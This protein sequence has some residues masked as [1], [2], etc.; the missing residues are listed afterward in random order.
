MNTPESSEASSLNTPN[1][2]NAPNADVSNN[3]TP[4][5]KRK[6]FYIG[7]FD[8]RG[9]KYYHHLYK[10]EST[11][12]A[13]TLDCEFD[14]SDLE[15]TQ[16]GG[17]WHICYNKSQQQE[18]TQ[19]N[20]AYEYLSYDDQVQEYFQPVN[21]L[22]FTRTMRFFFRFFSKWLLIPRKYLTISKGFLYTA[23]YPLIVFALALLLIAAASLITYKLT[24]SLTS[25][26][27]LSALGALGA[28][29]IVHWLIKRFTKQI[30][31]IWL[32]NDFCY[33][34]KVVRDDYSEL[35]LR[36]N[37]FAD[38]I[39]QYAET[40]DDDEIL[41]VF[42]SFGTLL[43]PVLL[44]KLHCKLETQESQSLSVLSLG[45]SLSMVPCWPNTEHYR[46][47]LRTI[48]NM[49]INWHDFTS[50]V[51]GPCCPLVNIYQHA[52]VQHDNDAPGLPKT[53]SARFH[54]MFS[55]ET[56]KAIK[57][58]RFRVHFQYLMATEK[59]TEYDYFLITAG[60][61]TLAQRYKDKPSLH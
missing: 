1:A 52:Q 48:S 4:V 37:S 60:N 3:E 23:T 29:A 34:D 58:D 9:I 27:A 56:Y 17:Q 2:P 33:I 14:V 45:Q 43:L 40:S 47:K 54:T 19:V 25:S 26:V 20:T 31:S 11:K 12:Q 41:I 10:K 38:R 22:F 46:S 24:L 44:D 49:P 39:S 30:T 57:K 61:Q 36:L 55:P 16:H 5:K 42:F 8:P 18:S 32:L 50:V 13:N 53:L 59:P 6:V 28:F 15:K 7:G 35:D 51:D 21:L